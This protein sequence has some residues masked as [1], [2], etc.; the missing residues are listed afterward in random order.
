MRGT[1]GCRRSIASRVTRATA[2][3]SLLVTT[4]NED[5][6]LTS[7]TPTGEQRDGIA[8]VVGLAPDGSELFATDLRNDVGGDWIDPLVAPMAFG[9][10]RLAAGGGASASRARV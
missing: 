5:E 8:R 10:G 9:T 4:K 6:L 1:C 2:R 7:T 3:Q